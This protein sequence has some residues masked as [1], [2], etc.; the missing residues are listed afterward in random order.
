MLYSIIL[1]V[2]TY[3][4]ML[5]FDRYRPIIALVSAAILSLPACFPWSVLTAM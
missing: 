4:L 1:F 3:V 2:L 5:A